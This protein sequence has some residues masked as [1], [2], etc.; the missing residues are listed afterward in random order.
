MREER[1]G[2]A[3]YLTGVKMISPWHDTVSVDR[4]LKSRK[5]QWRNVQ[6]AA[7]VPIYVDMGNV[8]QVPMES[9]LQVS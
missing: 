4:L 1:R 5:M 2:G 6:S 8:A 7:N 9:M 3:I